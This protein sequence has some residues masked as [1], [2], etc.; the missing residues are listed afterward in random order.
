MFNIGENEFIF[1]GI[2]DNMVYYNPNNY[3]RV[4]YAVNLCDGN[5]ENDFDVAIVDTGIERNNINSGCI[6]NNINNIQQNLT[7]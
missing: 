6:Y 3:K 1:S 7:L 2:I 4:G 5:Y